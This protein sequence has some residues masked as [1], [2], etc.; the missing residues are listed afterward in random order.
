MKSKIFFKIVIIL[1]FS[2]N[3]IYSKEIIFDSSNMNIIDDGNIIKAQ[4]LDIFIP[5]ENIK[6]NSK[7]GT[8]DKTKKILILTSEVKVND[9]NNKIN[10]IS[11]KI[12]YDINLNLISSFGETQIKI[13]GK[14]NIST[15]N[16][17]YDRKTFQI[18]SDELTII[19]DDINNTYNLEEEF[20]FSVKD[21]IIKSKKTKIVD[22]E[23]NNYILK[24]LIIDL[25]SN[26]ILGKD[27]TID[28]ENSYFK[29]PKNDPLLKGRSIISNNKNTKIYKSIFSTCSIKNKKCRGWE[30]LSEEF[31]HNKKDK[32][33]EYTNSWLKIF[34]KKIFY[35]PFFYH[36][37]PT[38][39]RRSGFLTPSYSNSDNLGNSVNIPYFKVISADKDIT[40]NPRI[41]ADNSFI[42]QNEYRQQFQTSKI[43]SD[44]S[45]NIDENGNNSHFFFNRSGK[46]GLNKDYELNIQ[47]VSNDNYLKIHNLNQNSSL[48]ENDSL[49]TSNLDLY[50]LIDNNTNFNTSFKV[51]EDLSRN[52]HDRY[53]YILPNFN[54]SKKIDIDNSY[55]GNFKYDS[56]GYHK[57]YD[58]NINE[59]IITNDFLFESNESFRDSG[60]VTSF[61]II[62]KNTNSHSNNSSNYKDNTHANLYGSIKYDINFPLKKDLN[63]FTSY[64][65]PIASLRYSP[66]GNNDISDNNTLLN[67]NNVFNI[68]RIGTNQQIEGGKSLS[69]GI[70]YKAENKKNNKSYGIKLANVIKDKKDHKLPKKTRL[71]QTRSDI[72]GNIYFNF[73]DK[74]N[75]DYVYSFDRDFDHTNL[76]GLNLDIGVNNIFTNF[77]YY[78]EQN[79]IG[80]SEVAINQT[81]FI[82]NDENKLSF[83]TSKDLKGDFTQYY[84][85]VY[86]YLTDCISISLNYNKKFYRDGSLKPNKSLS[87]LIKFIPFTEIRGTADAKFTE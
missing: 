43:I 40:F 33:F 23:N 71:N 82:I 85:F 18:Y 9:L 25:K 83:E 22:N 10:I 48:I 68:N 13:D 21:E 12:N 78:S 11:N 62:L 74:I 28:F 86:E 75:L 35:L 60:L 87:F 5:E 38:V 70:D 4:N 57:N 34:G 29:N 30:V 50:W 52:A 26:E 15:S 41:Y 84:D 49:L 36:P 16:I 64:L 31:N 69:L 61:D 37:D 79:D 3:S 54:F 20:S 6:I 45:L 65:T 7:Q 56:Y 73:N 72:F 77:Y 39:K 14:Y 2:I 55:N 81:S 19:K 67:F 46:I 80:N 59:S 66:N 53:Q 63:N 76:N 1:I 8:Y 44:F 24:D 17:F 58:T 42:F 47:N 27:I 51:Y 32:L